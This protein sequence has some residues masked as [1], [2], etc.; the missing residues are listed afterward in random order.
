M[1]AE[2]RAR[3]LTGVQESESDAQHRAIDRSSPSRVASDVIDRLPHAAVAQRHR[4]ASHQ[5]VNSPCRPPRPLCDGY[6][7]QA[8]ARTLD[9]ESDDLPLTTTA[10]SGY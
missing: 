2:Y 10:I 5:T 8:A 7:F 6:A 4:K 3:P 9:H 1:A